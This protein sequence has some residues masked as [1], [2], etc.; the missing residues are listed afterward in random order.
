M[1][2]QD[3]E[4]KLKSV[5]EALKQELSGIRTNRPSSRMIEDVK[6]DYFGAPTPL[7]QLGSIS[8]VP[9]RELQ[10]SVWDQNALAPIAKSIEAANLGVSVSVSGNIVR[11]TLPALSDERRM[12]LIKIVKN[13]VE[14]TKIKVRSSRDDANKKTDGAEKAKEISEDEKFKLRKKIQEA[15]DKT[16]KEIEAALLAK[17]KE[18]Q[19]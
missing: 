19:E 8:V 1:G 17:I 13:M 11:V 14:E 6:V 9:P 4:S 12:E 7:K 2:T 15:V 16:N 18:I 10:I 3:L 5:I